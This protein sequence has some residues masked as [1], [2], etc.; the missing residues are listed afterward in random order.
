M[1]HDALMP[2]VEASARRTFA[3]NF[4]VAEFASA[5]VVPGFGDASSRARTLD[6]EDAFLESR[7]A[8]IMAHGGISSDAAFASVKRDALASFARYKTMYEKQRA[9]RGESPV[10]GDFLAE[11]Q[12][13]ADAVDGIGPANPLRAF[14]TRAVDTLDAN[15]GWSHARKAAALRFLAGK[16]RRYEEPRSSAEA[17]RDASA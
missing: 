13:L 3:E 8:F 14:A 15:A 1:W 12:T 17:E 6:D 2:L 9:A 4:N 7:K 10:E 16:S 11:R 5:P